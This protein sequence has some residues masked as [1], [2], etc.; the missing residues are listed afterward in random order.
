MASVQGW[1]RLTWGSGAW[2]EYAPVEAT[3]EGLTSSTEDVTVVTD[4]VISVSLDELTSTAGNAVGTG[5]ANATPGGNELEW[6]PIG[7]YVVQSDYIFPITGTDATSYEGDVTTTVEIRAGWNRSKDI[8]TGAAIGWGDQQWGASGG[9]YAVSLDELTATSGTGSTVTTDQ[10]I[11]I[12]VSEAAYKLESSIGSYSI[13]ADATITVVAASEPELDADTG[14]VSIAISPGVYPTAAGMTSAVGDVGTSIFVTGVS[15][16]ASEG[17]VTQETSYMA[18]SE[19]AT[20]SVGTVNIQT[21]VT[22]TLTGVS[23]TSS[24][25]TLGGIFWSQVD[26]SNSSLTWTEVHKA[27]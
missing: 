23:A 15:A 6:K 16:T 1:G 7:T 9:S 18:P 25:G 14:S 3:G 2:N 17:D 5:I 11:T 22:F 10:I 8:T 13:T 19:E 24:T 27:A 26:D 20:T 12:D 21:D 4:Q